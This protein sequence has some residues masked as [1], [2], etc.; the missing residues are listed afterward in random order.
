MEKERRSLKYCK[1]N[2]LKGDRNKT[3]GITLIA[4]VITI[5]VLLILAGVTIATLTGDNGILTRAQEAKI[6]TNEAEDIEKIKMAVVE[7]Q[8]AEN[9]YQKLD[10][11]NLQDTIDSQFGE[12]KA[13]VIDN[14]NGTFSVSIPNSKK[15]YLID[16]DGNVEYN[17]NLLINNVKVGDYVNYVPDEVSDA[18]QIRNVGND[19]E[20]FQEKLNW[21][22]FDI[23]DGKVLL[24]SED[25]TSSAI[26]L[27]GVDAYNNG[28]YVLNDLCKNLYSKSGVAVAR[29]INENDIDSVS[30]FDKTSYINEDGIAYGETMQYTDDWYKYCPNLYN[31]AL[32]DSVQSVDNYPTT[33]Y[34]YDI[35][36]PLTLKNT[37][38]E[39]TLKNYINGLNYDLIK[40]NNRYWLASRFT[41]AP[42]DRAYFGLKMIGS[43]SDLFYCSNLYTSNNT[44]GSSEYHIVPI[45]EINS[46]VEI[47]RQD[48]NR[49]GSSIDLAWN[50]L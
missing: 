6:K 30:T 37:R 22:V 11:N 40:K 12:K 33:G 45:V 44:P 21:R 19:S 38:Y 26:T 5:I 24:I 41:A 13:N 43:E 14:G 35:A 23:K 47:D 29:S 9:G 36:K 31:E 32:D 42:S 15:T 4:L 50:I 20:F 10:L 16:T 34:A 39:Y 28:V 8:I 27:S 3:S 48:S 25:T 17:S 46:D 49:N 7:A 2:I 1:S 18:Y